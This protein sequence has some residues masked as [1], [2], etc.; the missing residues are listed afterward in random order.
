MS[1]TM[2]KTSPA[3]A[4]LQAMVA[5]LEDARAA[6]A[7]AVA[8]HHEL[9]DEAQ[10]I[11][12]ELTA[13]TGDGITEERMIENRARLDAAATIAESKR[14]GVAGLESEHARAEAGLIVERIRNQAGGYASWEQLDAEAQA[15]AAEAVAKLDGLAVRAQN[16][17]V[18]L[19]EAA[20]Q[21]RAIDGGSRTI[22]G[23]EI[24]GVRR[25]LYAGEQSLEIDGER[26][27]TMPPAALYATVGDALDGAA[28]PSAMWARLEG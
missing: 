22:E 1:K 10:R 21:L 28:I 11:S 24:E 16:R 26:L 4:A 20:E 8:R 2:T 17:N 9:R 5:R 14:R 25:V 27:Q 7:V 15:V 18:F 12:A 19:W 13:G 23:H 6:H 3:V